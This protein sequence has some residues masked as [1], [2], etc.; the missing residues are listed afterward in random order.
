MMVIKYDNDLSSQILIIY[1]VILFV[2]MTVVFL[3]LGSEHSIWSICCPAE[4]GWVMFFDQEILSI[5]KNW[6]KAERKDSLKEE[7]WV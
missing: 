7:M 6:E 3:Y 5:G 4:L 1:N 2:C